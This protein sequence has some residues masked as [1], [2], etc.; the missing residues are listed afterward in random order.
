MSSDLSRIL[1]L[2]QQPLPQDHTGYI[3]GASTS[4][5]LALFP[6]TSATQSPGTRL[7]RGD[8]P[9]AQMPSYGDM[10]EWRPEPR[11]SSSR[12]PPSAVEM[13]RTLT[14]S[15]EQKQPEGLLSPLASPLCPLEV[16]GLVCGPR[17]PS[18]PEHLSSVPKQLEFQRH[19]SDPGFSRS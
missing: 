15:S 17:Y 3:L 18:L 7:P 4:N 16:Q 12:M 8:P 1:K 9:P 6:A 5:D 10:D 2:L 13:D 19:G 11:N 14:L